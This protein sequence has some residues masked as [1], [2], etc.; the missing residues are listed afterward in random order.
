M[1]SKKGFTLVEVLIAAAIF[2]FALSVIMAGLIGCIAMNASS[3]NF[4]NATQH[5]QLI[6]EEIRNTTFGSIAGNI[7]AGNWNLDAAEI[8]AYGLTA[9]NTETITVSFSG[10]TLMDVTVTVT[11]NDL[12]ARARSL[13]LKTSI[14]NI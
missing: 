10:I 6:M 9:L 1:L 11:W 2:G 12:N 14:A 5:A 7:T 13:T 3:R 4:T 8:T